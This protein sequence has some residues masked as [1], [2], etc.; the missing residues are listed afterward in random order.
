MMIIKNIPSHAVH[1]LNENREKSFE[2]QTEILK[3]PKSDRYMSV[4]T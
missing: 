4:N 3:Q 1:S 2:F